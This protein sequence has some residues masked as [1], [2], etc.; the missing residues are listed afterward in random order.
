MKNLFYLILIIPVLLVAD[1]MKIDLQVTF[2]GVTFEQAAEIEEILA[3]EF[4]EYE[5]TLKLP[6]KVKVEPKPS[7]W[8]LD[9]E[10]PLLD[11]SHIHSYDSVTQSMLQRI[12]ED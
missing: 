12:I 1:S 7:F 10:I 2:H 11:S 5:Y 8:Y 3:D 6:D 9:E 4:C